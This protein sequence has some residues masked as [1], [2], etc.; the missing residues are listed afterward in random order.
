MNTAAKDAE[1]VIELP[2][3]SFTRN[4]ERALPVVQSAGNAGSLLHAIERVASNPDMDIEKI[5]RLFAMHQQLMAKEAESAFNVAMARAQ[6]KIVPI[7]ANQRNEHTR[8]VY[9]DLAAISR[10]IVPFYTAEGLSISFDSDRPVMGADGKPISPPPAG[11]F[12]T[13]AIV[14]HSGG[15]S[16]Q[17]HI[18]LP[19]DEVGV[20]G[21]AN[22]TPIQGVVSMT[23]YGRRVL[24]C[25]V[26]NVPITDEDGNRNEERGREERTGEQKPEGPPPYSAEAF[27]KNLPAWTKLIK[28]GKKTP[29]QIIAMVSSKAV[30]SDEQK[31]AIEAIKNDAPTFAEIAEKLEAADK[32]KDKSALV[33]AAELIQSV[34]DD[35]QRADLE[36]MY[37]DFGGEWE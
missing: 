23:T 15:H 14:S 3:E 33:A 30:L 5:E 32:A 9:A 28:S 2:K 17:H 11:W 20:K 19:S 6:S 22:K 13:I 8:S 26:F 1:R 35:K 25:M 7:V 29:A 24:T 37:E 10:V 31:K 4:D 27:T 34:A 36:K 18:D 16:R 21:N 12:R